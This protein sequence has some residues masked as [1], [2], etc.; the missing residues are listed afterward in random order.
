VY[1]IGTVGKGRV[2]YSGCYCGY[3][4]ALAGAER[5]LL[6]NL[7]RWLASPPAKGH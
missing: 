1:V 7:L 5:E 4:H 6:L 3:R 2:V